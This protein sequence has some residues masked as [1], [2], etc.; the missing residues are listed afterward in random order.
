MTLEPTYNYPLHAQRAL[1]ERRVQ[2]L[3]QLVHV[4]YHW[5]CEPDAIADAA[6]MAPTSTLALRQAR[7]AAGAH[8][9]LGFEVQ[10]PRLA[11]RPARLARDGRWG[12]VPR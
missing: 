5:L 2:D 6:I 8:A 4:R 10:G 11:A 7:M 12:T 1:A 3:E 9:V